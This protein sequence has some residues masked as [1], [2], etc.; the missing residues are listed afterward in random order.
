MLHVTCLIQINLI[1]LTSHEFKVLGVLMP[2]HNRLASRSWFK[3]ANDLCLSSVIKNSS[4]DI[5][6]R[7]N[8][9]FKISSFVHSFVR[10]DGIQYESLNMGHIISVII[11]RKCSQYFRLDLFWPT[12]IDFANCPRRTCCDKCNGCLC[13]FGYIEGCNLWLYHLPFL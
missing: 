10:I 4:W 2:Y 8:T 3:N 11:R 12:G 13:L 5:G 6:W 1:G 9:V 7:N